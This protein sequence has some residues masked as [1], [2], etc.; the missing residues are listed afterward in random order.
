MSA[1]ARRLAIPLAAFLAGLLVLGAALILALS[2]G[3]QQAP[4]GAGVGGPFTLVRQ[5]GQTVTEKDF[6]GAPFLVF[7]GFTHCP[8]VCPTTLFEVSEV[9]RAAGD[10]GKRVRALFITVDP[11]RDTPEVMKSYLGS[12]DARIVGL[13]GSPAAIDAVAKA[14]KAYAKKVPLKDGGY[15]MDHTAIVYLMDAKGRFVG[16]FNLKRSPDEAAR[17]LLRY[18]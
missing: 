17:D 3:Q 15:T 12:F 14:Y 10:K 7:F 11:E 4:G 16:S 9:L 2:P 18:L 6:A 8:D 1:R 5:D 13:T